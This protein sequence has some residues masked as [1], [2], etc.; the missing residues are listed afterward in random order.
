MAR[1][2]VDWEE[3]FKALTSFCKQQGHCKV[4]AN[5]K[6]NPQL[7]RWVAMQ[8]YR[9]KLGELTAKEIERLDKLGFEW[10]PTGRVWDA[11]FE[12]LLKFKK[13]QGHCDVPS[14]WARDLNLATW[15]SNQ[16]H[17]NKKGAL[18]PERVKRLNAIGF[19]W[20]VYG[21]DKTRKV[22]K[23][24]DAPP[25]TA[26]AKVPDTEE[27]LYHVVSEYIQYN[28]V[29]PLPAKLEK[30]IQQRGG[31]YPPYIPLPNRP[32]VFRMNGEHGGGRK[33]EWGGK[34]LLPA[35][36]RDYLNENGVLP[37]HD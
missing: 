12:R 32:L 20:A 33:I 3:M 18:D 9:R 19:A 37:P 24:K 29:G 17:R 16:R 23:G 6:K 13:S 5:W 27:R 26:Q 31:V 22:S 2:C 30:Y 25:E 1:Q 34:G 4:P 35:D 11:M 14:Q 8:R 21:K 7:G 15:V 10:S 28:G 36:V